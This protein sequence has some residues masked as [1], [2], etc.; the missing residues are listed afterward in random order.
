MEAQRA[1]IEG[2]E[3]SPIYFRLKKKRVTINK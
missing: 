3:G 1:A 2:R